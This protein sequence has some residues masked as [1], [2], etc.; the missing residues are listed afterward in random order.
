M[1]AVESV[2]ADHQLLMVERR[3]ARRE[4]LQG[5]PVVFILAVGPVGQVETF[6]G[7]A[8]VAPEP[9]GRHPFQVGVPRGRP[10]AD[11]VHRSGIVSCPV[12][13]VED[14]RVPHRTAVRR[15]HARLVDIEDVA[16]EAERPGIILAVVAAL[17]LQVPAHVAGQHQIG[18]GQNQRTGR[19]VDVLKRELRK[20]VAISLEALS[21]CDRMGLC[22]RRRL[23]AQHRHQQEHQQRRVDHPVAT[24]CSARC[25]LRTPKARA[26][27]LA[28]S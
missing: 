22:K 28:P 20:I 9:I 5:R 25:E 13:G 16:R 8:I 17:E 4:P 1:V 2:P 27:P 18:E 12:G 15:R 24:H 21:V 19:S 6:R 26:D 23:T 10:G 14:R 3:L 7:Q 11:I